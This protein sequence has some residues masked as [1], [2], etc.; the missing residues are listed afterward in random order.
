MLRHIWAHK[1]TEDS[2]MKTSPAVNFLFF[3]LLLNLFSCRESYRPREHGFP[4]FDLPEPRYRHYDEN[5]PFRFEVS[6]YAI[7]YND[8]DRLTEPH[9][10]N[11]KYPQLSAEVQLTYKALNGDMK[12]LNEH[13]EDSR[14]LINKHNIKAYGIEESKIRTPAG[15]DAYVFSLTGQVPTQFQF[16]TTDSSRHFLRGA[17]Y[18]RIATANDSLAPAIRYISNDMIHL[19]NTLQWKD[20]IR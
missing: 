20:E 1:T 3:L 13:T 14:K 4:R 16:Y 15:E 17:L 12:L 5:H 7:V 11:I 2:C 8:S 9:W 6:E 19:L 10:V 18:F